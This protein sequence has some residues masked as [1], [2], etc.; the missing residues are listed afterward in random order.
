MVPGMPIGEEGEAVEDVSTPAAGALDRNASPADLSRLLP[1]EL[2][3]DVPILNRVAAGAFT[4]ERTRDFSLVHDGGFVRVPV[5]AAESFALWVEG[6][7]M[8]P[9]YNNGDLVVFRNVDPERHVLIDGADYAIQLSGD[10]FYEAS[11][12][13]LFRHATKRG[14]LVARPW[15]PNAKPQQTMLR[16]EQ[17]SKLGLVWMHFPRFK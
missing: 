2:M 4:D 16:R 12:K 5:G 13:R 9:R 14:A 7:S 10:E 1:D 17:I 3:R 8:Q 11:F 15:N 6:E